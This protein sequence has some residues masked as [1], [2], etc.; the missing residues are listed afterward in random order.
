[1][2]MDGTQPGNVRFETSADLRRHHLLKLLE[3]GHEADLA[4]GAFMKEG[5]HHT[6]QAPE[7]EGSLQEPELRQT[8]RVMPLQQ[9]EQGLQPFHIQIAHPEAC[10]ALSINSVLLATMSVSLS[11]ES[12]QGSPSQQAAFVVWWVTCSEAHINSQ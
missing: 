10:R 7:D 5:G 12:P 4:A 9:V 3:V 11:P 1:M 8:L 6:P 2:P